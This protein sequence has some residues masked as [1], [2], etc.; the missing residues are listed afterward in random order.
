M[1]N[2]IIIITNLF[3]FI[4]NGYVVDTFLLLFLV[5]LLLLLLLFIYV[6]FNSY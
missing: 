3:V 1:N 6:S 2:N 5:F 4:L